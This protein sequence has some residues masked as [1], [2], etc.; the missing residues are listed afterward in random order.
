MSNLKRGNFEKKR[1]FLSL[2]NLHFFPVFLH[3]RVN[4][5]LFERHNWCLT[6][7]NVVIILFPFPLIQRPFFHLRP[8]M[9]GEI[10]HV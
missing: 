1:F 8:F 6:R 9:F 2:I 7:A 10:I 5:F 4:R 3:I